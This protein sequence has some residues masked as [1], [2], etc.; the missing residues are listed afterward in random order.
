MGLLPLTSILIEPAKV[1]FLN[2]AVN[3]GILSPIGVEQ[4]KETGKS[5][6]FLL[7]A[8]PGP[9][10]GVLIAYMIFGKGTAK[11]S[12]PGAGIIHFLGG[13]HEIYFPYI[14]MRPMLFLAVI[15]SG[16]SGVFTLVLLNGGLFAPSSPGS[17]IAI[18]AVTPHHFSAYIANYAAVLTMQ[19]C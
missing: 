2:N 15:L 18:T 6:L 13:I 17:I 5:I 16:M 3:H 10:L 19:L 4:A 7:E 1:L 8:N 12:A 14:L 11:K 9:G